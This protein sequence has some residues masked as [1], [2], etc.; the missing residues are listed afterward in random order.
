MR[1][2]WHHFLILSAPLAMAA[3]AA[4]QVDETD[5]RLER[6]IKAA[7]MKIDE[8]PVLELEPKPKTGDS[9]LYLGGQLANV[10][11]DARLEERL[12]GQVP[13]FA[14]G[15]RVESDVKVD[16]YRLGYRF[17]ITSARDA[18]TLPISVHSLMGLAVLDA[19][20]QSEAVQGARVEE[21]LFKGAPLIGMEMEW[22]AT[23][24][25]SLAGEMTS[26]VPL[27][28]MPWIFSGRLLG[29]YKLGGRGQEGLRAFWG[30]GYERMSFQ[31]QGGVISDID[32]DTGPML[33]LG[34]EARF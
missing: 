8:A 9:G 11:G 13:M 25:F 34:I 17:P 3:V 29:R 15:P 2:L 12:V 31:D 10:T 27:S 14:D 21:G 7:E 6:V 19:K 1:K 24:S 28:D 22:H 23:R 33:L 5:S 4:A 20:Y 32:S 18:D 26:T 16:S 30:V